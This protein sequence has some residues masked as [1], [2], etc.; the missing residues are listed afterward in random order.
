[1]HDA[2]HHLPVHRFHFAGGAG[3]RDSQHLERFAFRRFTPALLNVA[4]IVGAAFFAD[5]FDPPVLVLAWSVFVGGVL[6]LRSRCRSS[7]GWACM[8]R[9]RSIVASPACARAAS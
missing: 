9:W 4:F 1:V 6:Q 2:A 3:R 8:P 5:F 7:S